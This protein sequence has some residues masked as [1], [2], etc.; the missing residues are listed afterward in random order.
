MNINFDFNNSKITVDAKIYDTQKSLNLDTSGYIFKDKQKVTQALKNGANRINFSYS[1]KIVNLDSN[2][3]YLLDHWYP[4]N[5]GKCRYDIETNLPDSYQ[6]IYEKTDREIPQISFV[7]SKSFVITSKSYNDINVQTYF[8]SSNKS[9]ASTYLN[10]SIEYIKLY[11]KM[12]GEFPYKHFRVVENIHQTGYSMPTYT[13]IGSRLLNKPY[14]L[15]QSLGHEILHQYFGNAVFTDSS[16]GNWSEGLTTYLADDYY[17]RQT[18]K[19]TEHRKSILHEYTQFV[20]KEKEFEINAFKF[21]FD[22]A[23]MLIG[24]SKLSFVFYMLEKKIGSEQ[25]FDIIKKLYHTYEFKTLS[26]EELKSFFNKHSSIDLKL[27]FNQWLNKKGM[28]NFSIENVQNF[29]TK[30]GFMVSFDV[31]QHNN[32]HYHF[33]LPLSVQTQDKIIHKNIPITKAK[34]SIK[35]NFDSQVMSISADKNIELFRKLSKKERPLTISSLMVQKN[36]IAVVNKQ[37]KNKYNSIQKIFP[38]IKIIESQNIKFKELKENSIIFLDANNSVLNH[39][40]PHTKIN[41]NNSYLS[42][43]P[44]IYNPQKQMAILN[45]GLYKSSYFRML[46]HYSKYEEIIFTKEQSIKNLDTTQNGIIIELN[47]MPTVSKIEEPKSII[48]SI[49]SFKNERIIYVGESHNNFVHHLNQL[50]I[51]KA[52]HKSGKKVAIAMEMFQMPFQEELNDYIQGKTSLNEFL[53]RSEYFKRWKFD[54]NL[55]KPIIDYAKKYQLPIVAIN[56]DRS[57]TKHVSKKGLWT[58]NTQQKKLLPKSIDQSNLIYKKSLEN[59]FSQ[60]ASVGNTK[61]ASPHHTMKINYDFFYQSQLIWDEIMAENINNYL[62]KNEDTIMVVIV[63]S[64]HVEKHHGIPSRVYQKNRLP[65]KVILNSFSNAI[66][67]DMVITNTSTIKLNKQPKLGVYLH[68]DDKMRVMNTVKDSFA[69]KI[70]LQKEDLILKIN[71]EEVLGIEDIKRI[72]YITP[73]LEKS[74][75]TVQRGKKTVKLKINN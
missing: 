61:D 9:L 29:Y 16:S 31:I 73:E 39:I 17:K 13:L 25:F 1:K 8:L 35:L 15:E 53:K 20:N 21:R 4:K 11:E 48:N 57:I 74:T 60:H 18:N 59:I 5:K 58:L 3:I 67:N 36:L 14:M 41:V 52:L 44:H 23:S 71:E 37:D 64:G 68:S 75:V 49:K 62:Q 24:Y 32:N 34:Q 33:E 38:Q 6:T 30:E 45:F 65:Y 40:Y 51:I 7:A 10:K 63:G 19:E 72:L 42:V 22:K 27:F 69:Q 2:Y 54:Y 70:G 66:T 12:I 56:T 43:K 28:L 55:Y 46:K 47:H 26:F 50:K